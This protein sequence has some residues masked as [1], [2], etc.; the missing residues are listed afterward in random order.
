LKIRGTTTKY[1]FKQAV[2][3]LIPD[4]IIDRRKQGFGVP[5]AH[6]FRGPW[7]GF[8]RDLL[9]SETSRQRGILNRSYIEHLLRLNQR[10]R[11]LDRQLWTLLSFEQWCR[12]FLDRP[13][14]APARSVGSITPMLVTES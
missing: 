4:G 9:L 1:L 11:N 7:T 3:G 2:R 10:G 8:V 6:W 14:A 5:L 13:A 12:T